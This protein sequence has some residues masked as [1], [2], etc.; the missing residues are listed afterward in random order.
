MGIPVFTFYSCIVTYHKLSGLQQLTYYVTVLYVRS[1]GTAQLDPL[2]RVS[3]G[4]N[5]GFS[6]S[7]GIIQ[8]LEYFSKLI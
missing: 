5:L 8:G 6:W 2:L 7:Y 1:P 4:Q 3:Q